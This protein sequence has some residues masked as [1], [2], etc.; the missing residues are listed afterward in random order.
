MDAIESSVQPDSLSQW[1]LIND[2]M[3]KNI[4]YKTKGRKGSDRTN[5]FC[6]IKKT[7]KKDTEYK[8]KNIKGT[9]HCG[10]GGHNKQTLEMTQSAYNDLL[11]KKH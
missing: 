11:L 2:A 10:S 6:Y 5:L 1:M 4:G 3:I 9:N 7:Y 8:L